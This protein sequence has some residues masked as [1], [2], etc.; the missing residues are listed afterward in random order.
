[1]IFDI[2]GSLLERLFKVADRIKTTVADAAKRAFVSGLDQLEKIQTNGNS[3]LK[4]KTVLDLDA[5]FV[6]LNQ[7][8]VSYESK[9]ENVG[10]H[11]W[12]SILTDEQ[13]QVVREQ[14]SSL[15]LREIAV[16]LGVSVAEVFRA[17]NEIASAFIAENWKKNLIAHN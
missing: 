14:L 11:E 5:T 10:I 12:P 2:T 3:S 15:P 7:S 6:P 17:R 4:M 1:M 9:A 8:A 13:K 16:G